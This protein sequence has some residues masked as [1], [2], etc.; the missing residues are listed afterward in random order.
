MESVVPLAL[1]LALVVLPH[2]AAHPLVGTPNPACNAQENPHDYLGGAFGAVLDGCAV[3]DGDHEWGQSVAFLP[4]SHHG[5]TVCVDDAALGAT[6]PFYVG[7]DG[8]G[9]G[10][11]SPGTTPTDGLTPV[12]TG[13]LAVAFGAGA[14]GGWWVFIVGPATAGHVHA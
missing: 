7:A 9:D 6:V 14:D 11:I 1:A 4:A 2:A 8:N 3:G 5:S 10:V 13:C 12:G